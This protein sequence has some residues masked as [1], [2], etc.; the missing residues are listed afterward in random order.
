MK[1]LK[2]NKCKHWQKCFLLVEANI[3]N[4]FLHFFFFF[5]E[6]R[7]GGDSSHVGDLYFTC[8]TFPLSSKSSKKLFR[9]KFGNGGSLVLLVLGLEFS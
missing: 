2:P 4:I 5:L 9:F 6:E 3:G 1:K 8:L 7:K